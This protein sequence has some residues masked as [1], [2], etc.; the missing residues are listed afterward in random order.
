MTGQQ[1]GTWA[2]KVLGEDTRVEHQQAGMTYRLGVL[3]G[4]GIGRETASR[5]TRNPRPAP[6]RE[7]IQL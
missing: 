4:D 5:L 3:E 2:R 6:R 7:E 1:R